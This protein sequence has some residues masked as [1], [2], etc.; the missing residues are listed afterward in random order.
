[1]LSTHASRIA[2]RHLANDFCRSCKDEKE[3]ETVTHL[4][5]TCPALC[6][7]R[8]KYMSTYYV[9]DQEEVSEIR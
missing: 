1:M 8:M 5:G 7:R 9:D 2:L 6:Q 4:L 3:R